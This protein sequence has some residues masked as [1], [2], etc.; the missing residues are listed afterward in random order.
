VVELV[1]SSQV[2][3]TFVSTAWIADGE[4]SQGEFRPRATNRKNANAEATPHDTG[5][6]EVDSFDDARRFVAQLAP[7][8]GCTGRAQSSNNIAHV[9]GSRTPLTVSAVWILSEHLS[10]LRR[11]QDKDVL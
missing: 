7:A 9:E 1:S 6:L 4:G 5:L 8:S 11:L 2:A 3:T 10:P